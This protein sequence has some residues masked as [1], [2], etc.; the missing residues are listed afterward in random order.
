MTI[1][2]SPYRPPIVFLAADIRFEFEMLC[3]VADC[4]LQLFVCGT[5]L[6]ALVLS[7]PQYGDKYCEDRLP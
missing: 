4:T 2:H 5:A 7:T 6:N 1:A 3:L